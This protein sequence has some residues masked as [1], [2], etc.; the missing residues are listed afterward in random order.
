MQQQSVASPKTNEGGQRVSSHSPPRPLL[1]S[2]THSPTPPALPS[3]PLARSLRSHKPVVGEQTPAPLLHL[4]TTALSTVRP[5]TPS[6]LTPP[7][8]TPA[9]VGMGCR[10]CCCQR[11]L[12]EPLLRRIVRGVWL[13]DHGRRSA[14]APVSLGADPSRRVCHSRARLPPPRRPPRKRPRRQC[15]A[16]LAHTALVAPPAALPRRHAQ[17]SPAASNARLSAGERGCC[18]GELARLLRRAA[19][20]LR[21]GTL[22]CWGCRRGCSVSCGGAAGH[23]CGGGGRCR[24]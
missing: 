9:S 23:G 1:T 12:R 5:V 3:P 2:S 4:S 16:P 18:T 11:R 7:R 24:A 21:R 17:P 19:G 20:E 6:P 22:C 8:R 15:P 10:S 14:A 13:D